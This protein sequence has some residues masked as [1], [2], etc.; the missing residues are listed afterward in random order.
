MIYLRIARLVSA[1]ARHTGKPLLGSRFMQGR[2]F[3]VGL[4]E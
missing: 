1:A 3:C 2:Q 4:F